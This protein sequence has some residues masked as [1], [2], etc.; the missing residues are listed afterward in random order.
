MKYL[1]PIFNI[2][3]LITVYDEKE[4]Y[5]FQYLK[6][7]IETEIITVEAI[8]KW[9]I[10]HGIIVETKYKYYRY[11]EKNIYRNILHF[12]DYMIMKEN[13]N[14]FKKLY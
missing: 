9:C 6:R 2:E 5:Q 14:K 3:I 8:C 11:E 12:I 1:I 13:L 4:L 10:M 7:R